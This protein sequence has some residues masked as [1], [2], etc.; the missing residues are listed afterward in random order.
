MAAL[1]DDTVLST[2]DVELLIR[3]CMTRPELCST[4]ADIERL[5]DTMESGKNQLARQ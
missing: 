4:Q 3:I 2:E 1:D 5:I